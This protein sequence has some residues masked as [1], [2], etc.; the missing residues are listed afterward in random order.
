[1]NTV[2]EAKQKTVIFIKA[3]NVSKWNEDGYQFQLLK[4]TYTILPNS[5][6]ENEPDGSGSY[7]RNLQDYN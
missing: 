7:E 5:E 2:L 3:T 4:D 1:M 6:A